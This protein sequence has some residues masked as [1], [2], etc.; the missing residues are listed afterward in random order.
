MKRGILGAAL[1]AVTLVAGPLA[2][3]ASTTLSKSRWPE[4]AL[5]PPA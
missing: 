4:S 2:A 1:M 3:Q 5:P